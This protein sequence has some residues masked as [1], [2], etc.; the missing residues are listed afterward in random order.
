MERLG[1]AQKL[2][3]LMRQQGRPA[4]WT[5][6]LQPYD[7]VAVR[8]SDPNVKLSQP[9]VALDESVRE[10]LAK[11]V[12]DLSARI[13]VLA[14]PAPLPVLSNADFEAPMLRQN[15]P[16]WGFGTPNGTSISIDNKTVR[17]GAQSLRLTSTGP[18]LSVRSDALDVPRTGRLG[19]TVWL[20]VADAKQ[21]P[22]VRLGIEALSTEGNYYRFATVGGSGP[23]GIPI[24]DNWSRNTQ[25]FFYPV[26][27][28]PTSG[29]LDLHLRFDL[30]GA[31][32]IWIDNI[33]ISDLAF[34]DPERIELSKLVSL[35]D[36]KRGAGQYLGCLQLLESHW[37]KF[38][39]EH[40]PLPVG[41]GAIARRPPRQAPAQVKPPAEE[42]KKPGMFDRL[43]GMVPRF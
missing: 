20:K 42:A 6:N 43:K 11:R 5:L 9:R 38:L 37:P 12:S 8:F 28:V 2:P 34:A 15:V 36:Y 35:A 39:I 13:A 40:V 1:P 32:E 29:L 16:G 31:G 4:T 3:P 24:P 22:V 10:E 21:Q 33:Q 23:N 17:S 27:D 25:P 41:P 30:M 14:N 18:R 19:V 26:F 7:F